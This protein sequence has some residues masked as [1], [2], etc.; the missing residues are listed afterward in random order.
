MKAEA[1]DRHDRLEA[2]PRVVHGQL[3]AGGVELRDGADDAK[4]GERHGRGTRHG[5][6][7]RVEEILAIDAVERVRVRRNEQPR[8]D[9]VESGFLGREGGDTATGDEDVDTALAAGVET[10]S[11]EVGVGRRRRRFEPALV[12]HG[13]RRRGGASATCEQAELT[14]RVMFTNDG[15]GIVDG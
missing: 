12:G 15:E 7:V 11:H 13:E 1:E 2:E 10:P 5:C 4:G 6:H 3:G 9:G 8:A 14:G